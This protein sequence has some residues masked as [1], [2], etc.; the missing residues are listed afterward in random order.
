MR[1][2]PLVG[3]KPDLFVT[4]LNK[5][6]HVVLWDDAGALGATLLADDGSIS[7]GRARSTWKQFL[8]EMTVLNDWSVK[9][10][11]LELR[12]WLKKRR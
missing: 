12:K 4:R 5:D 7:V 6:V 9:A 11:H 8:K 2:I 10:V 1:L 3:G